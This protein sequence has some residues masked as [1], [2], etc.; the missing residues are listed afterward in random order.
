M[1]HNEPNITDEPGAAER[2]HRASRTNGKLGGRPA[3]FRFATD[4]QAPSRATTG[5]G[6]EPTSD[7]L[8]EPAAYSRTLEALTHDFRPATATARMLVHQIARQH[9]DLHRLDVRIDACHHSAVSRK[10]AVARLVWH[11]AMVGAVTTALGGGSVTGPL[12]DKL[13]DELVAL[14]RRQRQG[15]QRRAK[16]H[17]ATAI[18]QGTEG[19]APP[20]TDNPYYLFCEPATVIK[21]LRGEQTLDEHTHAVFDQLLRA[22]DQQLSRESESVR[23]ARQQ[24]AET[25][26][27]TMPT[28]ANRLPM[29]EC[30]NKL[31]RDT[32]KTI[33]QLEARLLRLKRLGA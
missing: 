31:R 14:A 16:A 22:V 5:I 24:L 29:L 17:V 23:F 8:D 33:E 11:D 25:L 1:L 13:A 28:F 27:Q 32:L 21:V 10:D 2:R 30:L 9:V 4:L 18:V 7:H 15:W 20:R 26:V 12:V 3:G 19:S 6:L